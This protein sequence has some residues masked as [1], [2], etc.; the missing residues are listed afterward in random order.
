[1]CNLGTSWTL[2][3]T[4]SE[5]ASLRTSYVLSQHF[6]DTR[7]HDIEDSMSHDIV[8]ISG[9]LIGD[10]HA[11]TN[12]LS[13]RARAGIINY[14]PTRPGALSVTEFCRSVKVSRSVFYKI[15][16]RATHES[17]A[18]LH[19]R[20][21]APKQPARRYGPTSSTSSCESAN[22][23]RQVAGTTG[24]GLSAKS[25]PAARSPHRRQ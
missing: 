15:R 17:T 9:W 12:S 5:T 24:L 19:P 6:V 14:D 8:K 11:M 7:S 4:S 18:A 20:S 21:R 2:N 1:M 22:S 25:S 10:S 3:L 23:S 13:P 16:N